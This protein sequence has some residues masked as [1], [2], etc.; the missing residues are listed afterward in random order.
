MKGYNLALSIILVSFTLLAAPSAAAADFTRSPSPNGASV[1]FA[2]LA[3]GDV[4]PP[5]FIVRFTI[6]GMGIAPAGVEVENTGHFHLLIDLET[7]PDMNGPL[8][9]TPQIL[10]FGKG[11]SE[12]KLDL[13]EGPHT[14]RVMLADHL[15]VP[16][17]PPVISDPIRITVAADAPVVEDDVN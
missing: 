5:G 4:V 14:L 17:D 6:S 3:D 12:T 16:H 9:A 13:A 10:H 11:Q 2:N 1:G 15:H 7:L 8:P